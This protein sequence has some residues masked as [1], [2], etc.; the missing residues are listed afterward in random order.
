[1]GVVLFLWSV[2]CCVVWI[3]KVWKFVFLGLE[4]INDD[5]GGDDVVLMCVVFL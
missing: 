2:L 5:G 3:K 1:M 4:I